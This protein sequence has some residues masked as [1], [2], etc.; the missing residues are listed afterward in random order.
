MVDFLKTRLKHLKGMFG[1]WREDDGSLLAAAMAYYATFSFFP[2]LLVMIA[3][4]G[5]VLQFSA[6]AQDAQHELLQMLARNTSSALAEN[7]HAALSEIRTRAVISGPLGIAA[8]L[9]AAAVMFT[10]VD[11]VLDRVWNTERRRRTGIILAVRN[12]VLY[13]FRAFLM[14]LAVGFLV[15]IGFIAGMAAVAVQSLVTDLPLGRLPW[16]LLQIGISVGLNWLLFTVTYKVLPKV[17]VRWS[18]ASRG[19][20]LAAVLWEIARQLLGVFMMS[21][22]YGAYGLVGSIIVLMLWLYIACSVL[23][24]GAEYVRVI[25]DDRMA[26]ERLAS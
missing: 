15:F 12:T 24:L 25:R 2:M 5:F 13:R 20:N 9:F 4:L 1:R 26:T 21:K 6:S 3:A 23:L 7:V 14:L 8:L 16:N 22:N 17:K 11:A 19:G 10:H 18:E